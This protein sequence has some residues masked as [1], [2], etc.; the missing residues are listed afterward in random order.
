MQTQIQ[1]LVGRGNLPPNPLYKSP[2]VPP[3]Y[4][5]LGRLSTL[6]SAAVTAAAD[7]DRRQSFPAGALAMVSVEK[8]AR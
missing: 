2:I 4:V 3:G 6:E 1:N 5:D 8:L 7:G